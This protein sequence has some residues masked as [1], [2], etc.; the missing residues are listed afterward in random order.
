[1]TEEQIKKLIESAI[2]AHAKAQDHRMATV[3]AESLKTA[4]PEALK[5][6]AERVEKIEKAP[7]HE[8]KPEPKPEPKK[9]DK[10]EVPAWFAEYRK[11]EEERRAKELAPILAEREGAAKREAA[12]K[13]LTKVAGDKKLPGAANLKALQR[14]ALTAT[15][16][17]SMGQII[18]EYVDEAKAAK[19]DV[20]QWATATPGKEGAKDQPRTGPQH[21]PAAMREAVKTF[22]RSGI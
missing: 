10:D 8:P 5:P 2:E 12:L 22:A 9:G 3:V 4:L 1:M 20:T 21:D 11:A 6:I 18:D 17:T 19:I 16:E 13:M 14:L 15:D 7:A